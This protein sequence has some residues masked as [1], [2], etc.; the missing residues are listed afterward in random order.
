[1]SIVSTLE[2]LLDSP[3]ECQDHSET[4]SVGESSGQHHFQLGGNNTPNAGSRA[5]VDLSPNSDSATF[6]CGVQAGQWS[7]LSLSFPTQDNGGK[8]HDPPLPRLCKVSQTA[9]P[10]ERMKASDMGSLLYSTSSSLL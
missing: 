10:A 8:K 7:S 5:S 6:C 9:R 3:S 1:M 2:H 4:P